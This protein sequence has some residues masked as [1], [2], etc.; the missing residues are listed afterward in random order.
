MI[1][2]MIQAPNYFDDLV[3]F[4]RLPDHLLPLFY[5]IAGLIQELAPFLGGR[6]LGY[7]LEVDILHLLTFLSD[8]F[9]IHT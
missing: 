9:F 6:S 4:E 5:L 8:N 3:W 7:N 2:P 1:D